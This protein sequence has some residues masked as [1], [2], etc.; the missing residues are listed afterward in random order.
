MSVPQDP[1]ILL[2]YINTLLR[3]KYSTLEV[4]CDDLDINADE[5]K[6]KLGAINY[7]YDETLNKFC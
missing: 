1:V 4:L 5:I 2:S 7:I 6:A 3:D